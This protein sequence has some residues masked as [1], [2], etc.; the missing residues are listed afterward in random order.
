[1]KVLIVGGTGDVGK[2]L[3]KEF[4]PYRA[5]QYLDQEGKVIY[6]A[7]NGKTSKVFL[8]HGWGAMCSHIPRVQDRG[9]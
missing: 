6:A 2:Y 7:K 3:T 4:V 8:S 9:K 5:L 1:M